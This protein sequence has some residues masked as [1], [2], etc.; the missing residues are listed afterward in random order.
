MSPP[1]IEYKTMKIYY[2][3]IRNQSLK[4]FNFTNTHST[5]LLGLCSIGGML[6][7]LIHMYVLLRYHAKYLA[8]D[9]TSALWFWTWS[10][11]YS[12]GW[13]YPAHTSNH[14][15][16]VSHFWFCSGCT[17]SGIYC[18]NPNW[19]NPWYVGATQ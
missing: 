17:R 2:I 9:T 10:S 6:W 12:Q 14:Y 5:R 1:T 15:C 3:Y 19:Q 4:I 7:V 13:T 11:L 8:K 16:W 18:L